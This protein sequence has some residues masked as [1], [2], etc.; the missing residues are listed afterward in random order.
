MVRCATARPHP[1]GA[2]ALHTLGLVTSVISDDSVVH[3]ADAG[4]TALASMCIQQFIQQSCAQPLAQ[5]H[6]TVPWCSH[7]C[8]CVPVCSCHA[9]W[10][11]WRLHNCL[12]HYLCTSAGH[13]ERA[14]RALVLPS[15]HGCD[16]CAGPCCAGS[17]GT[18]QVRTLAACR[19]GHA[20]IRLRRTASGRSS[21]CQQL[22]Q[23][24]LLHL[25]WINILRMNA[26]R[27]EFTS[28][29]P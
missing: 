7:T 5:P 1:T 27:V 17:P 28:E 6:T 21:V 19:R 9:H 20:C 22:P 3:N 25:L 15:G 14:V 29:P 12:L 8:L 24:H 23:H 16:G 26:W 13:A 18:R 10:A 2:A 4:C 11:Y